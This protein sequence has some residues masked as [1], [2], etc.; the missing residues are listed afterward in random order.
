MSIHVAIRHTTT[1]HFVSTRRRNSK[2]K[3]RYFLSRP[4]LPKEEHSVIPAKAGIQE[5]NMPENSIP[6]WMPACAG[7]TATIIYLRR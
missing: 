7:M 4:A 2:C 1:Y 6:H 5:L 3:G